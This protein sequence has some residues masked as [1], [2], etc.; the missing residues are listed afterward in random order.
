MGVFY[1][2]LGISFEYRLRGHVLFC[3]LNFAGRQRLSTTCLCSDDWAQRLKLPLKQRLVCQAC[4]DVY[5]RPQ[6][7]FQLCGGDGLPPFP[8]RGFGSEMP[9]SP[10]RLREKFFSFIAGVG[11]KFAIV[12]M[13]ISCVLCTISQIAES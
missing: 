8:F 1:R 6:I 5:L 3:K 10:C 2:L 13:R 7:G 12:W 11:E 4:Q 9:R